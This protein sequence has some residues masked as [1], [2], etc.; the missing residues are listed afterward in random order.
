MLPDF[1]DLKDRLLRIAM[2]DFARQ[3]DRDGLIKPIKKMVYFEGGRFEAGDV[4]GYVDSFE[5]QLTSVP[6][7]VSRAAIIERGIDA[8]VDGLRGA[9]SLHLEKM[10]ELVLRRASEA[11]DRVGNAVDAS[12]QPMSA[13]LFLKM[14][15]TI[16]IDFLEN[17]QPDLSS[18]QIVTHPSQGE[19]FQ[20]MQTEWISDPSFQARYSGLM[21]KK[22]DAWRDRESNRKLVD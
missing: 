5:P 15:E 10:H 18:V 21:S 6:V 9:A 22:R 12:G 20:R 8:F 11:I 7:E 17:G 13:D 1:P 14:L 2:Y 3:I 4:S 19:A 16:D